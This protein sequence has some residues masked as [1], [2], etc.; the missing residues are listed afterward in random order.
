MDPLKH[1][2]IDVREDMNYTTVRA[3][4]KLTAQFKVAVEDL[5]HSKVGREA[6]LNNVKRNLKVLI[7]EKFYGDLYIKLLEL[8]RELNYNTQY[9][10]IDK[11]IEEV[12]FREE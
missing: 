4:L 5:L 9:C 1:I 12:R 3:I 6:E 7:W 2:V 10:S 8:R 11:I